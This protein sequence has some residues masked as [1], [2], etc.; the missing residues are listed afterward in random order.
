MKLINTAE[1]EPQPALLTPKAIVEGLRSDDNEQRRHALEAL[2]PTGCAMLISVG[3][4][5]TS[6]VTTRRVAASALFQA[7]LYAVTQVGAVIGLKLGWI[8]ETP[9]QDGIQV[10]P[11][12][13]LPS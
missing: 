10:V 4:A 5:S 2:F 11:A 9:K 3:A 8:P 6:V 12:D 1:N 7:L 13:A